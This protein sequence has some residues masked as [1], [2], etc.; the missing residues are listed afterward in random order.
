[1]SFG[2]NLKQQA[3][4][5]GQ[6][7]MEKLLADEQRAAKLV[8]AFGKVQRGKAAFDKG[9][10]QLMHQLNFA[11]KADFK[12]LGKQLSGVKRRLRE[13]NEKLAGL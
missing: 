11:A 7:A 8:S 1:M 12:A 6:K 10:Q 9:Q 2:S 13:L 3:F 5:L 4:G